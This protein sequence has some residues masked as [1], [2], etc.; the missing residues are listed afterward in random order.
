MASC[1]AE[2]LS[3]GEIPTELLSRTRMLEKFVSTP[4]SCLHADALLVSYLTNKQTNKYLFITSCSSLRGS[5]VWT[6]RYINISFVVL[7]CE[8]VTDS[9]L[10]TQSLL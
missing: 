3:N 7:C 5:T 4:G 2:L 1:D 8:V 6:E 9:I 10:R